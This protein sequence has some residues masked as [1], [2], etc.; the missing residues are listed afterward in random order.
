[1]PTSP[2]TKPPGTLILA[3]QLG[4]LEVSPLR[5]VFTVPDHESLD[6]PPFQGNPCEAQ[7]EANLFEVAVNESCGHYDFFALGHY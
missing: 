3:E 1:M 7:R 6:H 4:A 2:T 5:H